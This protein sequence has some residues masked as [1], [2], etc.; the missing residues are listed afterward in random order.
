MPVLQLERLTKSYPSPEGGRL[1]VLS[2]V[3][4]S[5]EKGEIVSITGRSGSG[6]STLLSL[7]A[8]LLP[9]DSGRVLYSGKDVTGLKGKEL[10][11]LRSFSMGFVFQSSLLL[12][13]FSALENVAMPLLIQGKRK[14]EAY[15]KAEELL[16]LLSLSGRASHR[17]DEL[18]G[19][20]KQ[21][22]AIAR[23]LVTAP[24]IIFAD[25]P[26]GLLDERTREDVENALFS[27]A[28]SLGLS[29]LLVT[30]DPELAGK[31]DRS[32]VLLGGRLQDG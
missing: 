11:R 3:D 23:A 18:S 16:G 14:A 1:S 26:T 31:A 32:L 21:R 13:D 27:S 6:K 24:E 2:S 9:P 5:L 8:L 25:E 19:G 29:M 7:A 28:R 4:L 30:H 22:V 17:P 20:E 10:S 15:S 12:S